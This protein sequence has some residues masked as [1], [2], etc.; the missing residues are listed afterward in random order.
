MA[1]LMKRL[2][3]KKKIYGFDSFD[4]FPGYSKY[5]EFN[6]FFTNK[7]IFDKKIFTTS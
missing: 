2:N 6:Q 5:D 3:S 7:K 1:I 4:G